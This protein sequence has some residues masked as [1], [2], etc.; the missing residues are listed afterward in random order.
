MMSPT[1]KPKLILSPRCALFAPG[2]FGELEVVVGFG[3]TPSV[4]RIQLPEG[5]L[6]EPASSES[7]PR[8][9]S[10]WYESMKASALSGRAHW[11]HYAASTFV[12]CD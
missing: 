4:A 5:G 12:H 1:P 10:E 3:S 2:V 6:L 11:L 7:A 9:H 8:W